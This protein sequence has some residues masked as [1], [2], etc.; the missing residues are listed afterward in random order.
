MQPRAE[1]DV[2]HRYWLAIVDVFGYFPERER[3]R[4]K[5]NYAGNEVQTEKAF[6]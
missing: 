4:G 6:C 3:H 2:G 1:L 5:N